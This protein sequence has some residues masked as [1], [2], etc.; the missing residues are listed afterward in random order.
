MAENQ[1]PWIS[2]LP[3]EMADIELWLGA[4]QGAADT[5]RLRAYD[6]ESGL[7]VHMRWKCCSHALIIVQCCCYCFCITNLVIQYFT[8]LQYVQTIDGEC[9]QCK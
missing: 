6:I 2:D 9:S 7:V 5:N 3:S 4:C 1:Q 8:K